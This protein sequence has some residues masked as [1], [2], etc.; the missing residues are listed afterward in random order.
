MRIELFKFSL[1]RPTVTSY[2]PSLQ[3][4]FKIRDQ[5]QSVCVCLCVCLCAC[6][7]A[8]KRERGGSIWKHHY[9]AGVLPSVQITVNFFSLSLSL[10]LCVTHIRS[11][12]GAQRCSLQGSVTFQPENEQI[13]KWVKAEEQG[14]GEQEE[15]GWWW[16]WGRKTAKKKKNITQA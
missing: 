8:W 14:G 10:S 2:I 12:H 7:S 4:H 3:R 5:S 13:Q 6:M 15:V 1:E 11:P 9:G 16:R